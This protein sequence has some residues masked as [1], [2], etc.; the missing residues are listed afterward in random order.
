MN[1]IYQNKTDHIRTRAIEFCP[2]CGASGKI[3]YQDLNDR[4]F[5]A[6]GI[7]SLQQCT[8]RHCG[9]VWL[10]PTPIEADIHLAYQKY[11]TH[12]QQPKFSSTS[13]KEIAWQGYRSLV[14]GNHR[15]PATWRGKLLGACFFLLP[16]RKPALEYPIRQLIGMP[17]GLALEIGCGGGDL[18]MQMKEIGWKTIGIDFDPGAVAASMQR[19]LDVREGDL[20][21]QSF[22]DASFDVVLMNHVLEHLPEPLNT[23]REIKRILRPR[24]RLILVTPNFA[25]WGSKHFGKDWRGLEPPRHLHLFNQQSALL[26]ANRAEF[27]LITVQVSVRSAIQILKES[28]AL[29]NPKI[30]PNNFHYRIFLE[31]IWMWEWLLTS[32]GRPAGEELLLVAEKQDD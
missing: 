15:F 1:Q 26:L 22:T 2:L 20:V 24:G 6:P 21:A 8:A 30:N 9:L 25:S 32:L 14:F 3:I 31:A 11:Y 12:E 19:G 29:K 16:N 27:H 23:M 7:W 4:L 17:C 18:L 5:D 13:F 10:Y 28:V